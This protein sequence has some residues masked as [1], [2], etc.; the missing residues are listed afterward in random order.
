MSR[1]SPSVTATTALKLCPWFGVQC[2][3][4]LPRATGGSMAPALPRRSRPGNDSSVRPAE[5][6]V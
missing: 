1:F 5:S 3:R 6:C 2:C 4:V